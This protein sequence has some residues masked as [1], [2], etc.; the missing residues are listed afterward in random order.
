MANYDLF[1]EAIKEDLDEQALYSEHYDS[2][3]GMTDL[4]INS[5]GWS[6]LYSDFDEDELIEALDIISEQFEADEQQQLQ[7][8]LFGPSNR[9]LLN[10]T[11]LQFFFDLFGYGSQVDATDILISYLNDLNSGGS[12][13]YQLYAGDSPADIQFFFESIVKQ[14][15]LIFQGTFLPTYTKGVPSPTTR[16][17]RQRSLNAICVD[18]DPMPVTSGERHP[19]SPEVLDQFLSACP[20]DLVPNYI[21]LTGNGIHLWYIFDS[22]IQVFSRNS[23][24]VRKLNSLARGLYR[25]VELIIEGSESELDFSCCAI[26][27][28]FRAPGSLTKYNDVV[29]CFCPEDRVYRRS[30]R[31]AAE[32]SRIV[33]GY[34]GAEFEKADILLD[35]DAVWKTRKQITEEHNAWLEQKM[36]NPASE[37]QLEFLFDLEKQGLLKKSE[38][39]SLD[40]INSLYASELIRKALARRTDAKESATT[41]SY[42]TWRTKPHSL[43]SGSTGGVYACILNSITEVSVGRRYNSLHMLSGVAYMMIKP[44]IP[45]EDVKEDFYKLLDTPWAKAG[46]PLTER[47]IKNALGGYNPNNRQTVNSIITTLGFS[48]FKPP[49]KRNGRK[50]ADH[51]KLVAENKIT[52]T[53]TKIIDVLKEK[54]EATKSEV[55]RITGLSRPTVTKHW[56]YCKSQQT[57]EQS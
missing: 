18:I 31:N 52:K 13:R 7:F 17:S 28:G 33:A 21:C 47:D 15:A 29:R 19:I 41:S 53:R 8:D 10:G 26:N 20:D 42:S 9:T 38:I 34:L 44:G 11:S 55:S 6:E 43:I 5:Y 14:P 24:R 27:H 35:S 45:K 32:L 39:E 23:T 4:L 40:G 1:E 54:P 3:E 37:A 56:E 51:L 50:Q 30:S 2:V 16:A 36:K 49:A 48:P 12:Q 22:P 46:T 57:E 25:C